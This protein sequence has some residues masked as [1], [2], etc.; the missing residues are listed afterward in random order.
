MTDYLIQ[1]DLERSHGAAVITLKKK[2]SCFSIL[3]LETDDH[4]EWNGEAGSVSGRVCRAAAE[5]LKRWMRAAKMHPRH[6][7]VPCKLE[8]AV[9]NY[10]TIRRYAG[11]DMLYGDPHP[12]VRTL[13][14]RIISDRDASFLADALTEMSRH[15]QGC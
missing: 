9:T 3:T 8:I 5:N 12:E 6:G 1:Y 10:G 14:V 15:L 13:T 2:G 11:D 4:E 7:R